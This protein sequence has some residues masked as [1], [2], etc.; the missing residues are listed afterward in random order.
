[1]KYISIR[2][3]FFLILILNFSCQNYIDYINEPHQNLPDPKIGFT[4]EQN[5]NVMLEAFY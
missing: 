1:M 3:I 4:P 5:Y 2:I